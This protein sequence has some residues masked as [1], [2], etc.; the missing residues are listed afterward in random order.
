VLVRRG[1][2]FG[3]GFAALFT[4]GSEAA[5][6]PDLTAD[7]DR[8]LRGQ[9]IEITLRNL[10]DQRLRLVSP[11]KIKEVPSGEVVA[12]VAIAAD[13]LPP[14]GRLVR[15]WDQTRGE[16]EASRAAPPRRAVKPGRFAVIARTSAGRLLDPFQIGEYFTIGFHHLPE[17]EFTLF[18]HELGP[19]EQME[20]QAGLPEPLRN[21]RVSGL[22][23]PGAGYNPAWSYTM[24]PG[25]ILLDK[26]FIELC[27]ASPDYVEETLASWLGERWCPWSS[28]VDRVGR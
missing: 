24:G 17:A 16:S 22:V 25:S 3:L 8:Y 9:R 28:Y 6:R 15:R 5:A 2:A 18:S 26:G 27:D 1:I 11:W 14:G 10:S 19:I 21:L 20:E 7:R 4:A 13:R 12:R 23:R